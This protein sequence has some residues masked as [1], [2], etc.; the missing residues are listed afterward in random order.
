MT[1]NSHATTSTHLNTSK[2]QQQ[3]QQQQ[4]RQQQ[5]LETRLEPQVSLFSI[6]H[7]LLD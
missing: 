5:G 1:T 7:F 3:Q 2:R 6:F 4:R